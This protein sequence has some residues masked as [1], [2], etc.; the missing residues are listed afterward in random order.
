MPV[1]RVKRRSRPQEARFG[2]HDADVGER[3]FGEHGGDVAGREGLF[4]RRD[5]V[6]LDD[7]GRQVHVDRGADVAG[8]RAGDAAGADGDERLVDRAVVAPVEDQHLGPPGDV[9]GDA[10]GEAVGVGRRHRDLPEGQAEAA[11]ELLGHPG[12]VGRRQ[13][14][15]HALLELL[16]DGAHR[17]LGRVA[18]HGA[19]VAQAEVEVLVAVDA[20][21]RGPV[22]FGDDQRK[23]TRPARHPVHRHAVEKVGLSLLEEVVGD[24]MALGEQSVFG[25]EQVVQAVAIDRR[26]HEETSGCR[27]PETP[28]AARNGRA[29]RLVTLFRGSDAAACWP[30]LARSAPGG[31][32]GRDPFA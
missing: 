8:T 7:L 4:E 15:G 32:S 9:A 5:V 12:G 19:G 3:R 14:G 27:A 11:G 6:E 21:K 26:G 13:H 10:Q 20:G 29:T 1:S 24:G 16:L 18:R 17:G 30:L 23:G 2:Q 31:P 25:V 22:R 28:A